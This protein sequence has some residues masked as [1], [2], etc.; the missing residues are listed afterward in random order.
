LITASS[1]GFNLILAPAVVLGALAGRWLLVR[2]NQKLFDQLVLLLSAI[3]GVLL[4]I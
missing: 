2:I 4:V 1:F 3:G